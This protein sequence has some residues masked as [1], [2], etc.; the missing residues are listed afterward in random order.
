MR[1]RA[2][3]PAA[4]PDDWSFFS[5][6]L[7]STR[8]VAQAAL[9]VGMILTGHAA[10]TENFYNVIAQDGAD[11]SVIHHTDGWYY[12]TKTTGGNVRLWRSRTL[13]GLDGSQS[14]VI[15]TPTVSTP[16]SSNIWAPEIVRLDGKWYVYF[17][18]DD[19]DN[20]NHRMYVLENTNAD[21][22]VGDWTFRGQITD[23]TDRWA[24]DGTAFAVGTKKYFIWSGWP[25]GTNGKQN[26][27]IAEMSNPWTISSARVQISTPTYAWE[28]N[29]SPTVNEGP[30]VIVRN[31]K[32]NLVYSASGSWTDNY[33][34]G[35]ITADVGSNFI[36]RLIMDQAEHADFLHCEY[37]LG[38]G[39]PH[40]HDL[41]G[42]ERGLDRI[43]QRPLAGLGMDAANPR[44]KIHLE[45]R[46]HTKPRNAGGPARDDSPALG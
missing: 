46:R 24:I 11:P 29:T 19:G 43:S 17:A 32:I 26:L 7:K 14:K 40:L 23:A 31:G 9:L 44:S 3:V 10:P 27:Y 42:R 28:T 39:A 36:E 4:F 41:A 6:S 16:Y 13:S 37:D 5:L 45:P 21:P 2:Q 22:F 30:E 25:A 20:E 33:C 35:L 38:T 18:A 34:L 12:Y 8:A 15:W 1:L